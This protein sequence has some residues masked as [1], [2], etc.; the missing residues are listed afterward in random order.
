MS[1]SEWIGSFWFWAYLIPL[2]VIAL[3]LIVLNRKGK[4]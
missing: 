3:V 1:V 2:I 4:L